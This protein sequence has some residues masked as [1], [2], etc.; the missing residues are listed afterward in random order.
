MQQPDK[1]LRTAEVMQ[2]TGM[3]RSTLWR[4]YR[5]GDFPTPIRITD[6]SVGW[7]L[8]DVQR[9]IADRPEAEARPCI[10]RAS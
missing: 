2:M 10:K 7:R 5:H 3:S 8:S 6:K 1:I 9:W 4:A